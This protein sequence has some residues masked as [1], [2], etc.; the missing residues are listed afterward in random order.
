MISEVEGIIIKETT[1]GETSKIINVYTKE[2]GII[3]IM[4]KGAK[5]LK[6]K[7]RASTMKLTYGKFNI[8]YKE[9]KLSLL[10]SV[11][12]INPL[13]NIK[14]DILKISYVSYLVD[15]L[16]QV[17]K[18]TDEQ[19][20][21]DNFINAILKI[22]EGLDPL[23]ITNII[24]VKYLEY[25]GVGLNLTSCTI[26]GNKNNIVT[27]ST[28]KGGLVCKDC[29]QNERLLSLKTIKMLNMY[30]LVD[31]KSISKLNIDEKIKDEINK[32]LIAYY[33]DFTGLYLKSKDF[34]KTL[35]SL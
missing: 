24:E 12:V 2:Y 14:C 8:Y 34:L 29:Y 3:G 7:L 28:E 30:Y 18:Q 23:V 16:T 4:C 11:D 19:L 25:L 10:S 35:N 33:D 5:S 13:A 17:I 31:I 26:C 15:L 22:E 9:N 20:L 6:S 1:Y 27:L 32:F 21:Y